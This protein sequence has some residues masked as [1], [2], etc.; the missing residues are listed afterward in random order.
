MR[1]FIISLLL[2]AFS[3]LAMAADF[4]LESTQISAGGKIAQ[5]QVYHGY[6][7]NGGNHSPQLA[8]RDAPQ[9]TR[10]FALTV[11]DPDAPTGHGWWHWLI[12]N[13]PPN[14]HQLRSD[15]GDP[16]L[17]VAPPGSVQSRTDFGRPGYGGPCPPRH[18]RPHRYQ[19]TIYALDTARLTLDQQASPDTVMNAINAH[20]LDQAELMAYYAR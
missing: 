11:F 15:A 4:T 8:W 1:Q 16:V 19:F 6:G 9:S 20:K 5:A 7:C 13:I 10:S 12:F 18:D 2:C 17:A 14:V 3:A